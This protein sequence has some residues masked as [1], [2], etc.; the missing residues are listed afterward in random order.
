MRVIVF[1]P[2]ALGDA[3]LALPALALLRALGPC[4]HVTLVARADVLPLARAAGLADETHDFD[5]PCW[6]ALW[7]HSAQLRSPAAEVLHTA[8]AVV[9]WCA[10]DGSLARNL[11]ARGIAQVMVAP[12]WQPARSA[13]DAAIDAPLHT[14]LYLAR[15]LGPVLQASPLATVSQLPSVVADLARV[16]D[17]AGADDVLAR[18]DLPPGRFVALHPGSGGAAKRWPAAC[19]ATVAQRLLASGNTP[20]LL[21][22]P[23][24]EAASATT[25][26]ALGQDAARVPVARGLTLS[27][28]VGVLRRSAAYLGNDSGVSHLAG[29]AGTA[30]LALFGPTDP[31]VWAP[32]GP[33]A[34]VLRAPLR[35]REA[36]PVMESLSVEQVWAALH[37]LVEVG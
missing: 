34:Q 14:A 29:L 27:A 31:A 15:T 11:F 12:G 17:A 18:L 1:R 37:A 2:G 22:G 13:W 8:D 24:D 23:A 16:E 32:L 3:L 19:F 20:L 26:A 36:V 30:T 4:T 21:A 33:R 5:L 7:Q 6:S 28:L 10:D 35:G 9:A 25:V